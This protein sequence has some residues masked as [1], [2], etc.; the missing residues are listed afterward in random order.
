MLRH[1][2]CVLSMFLFIGVQTLSI[3]KVIDPTVTKHWTIGV[4]QIVSHPSLDAVYKGMLEAL[5]SEGIEPGKNLTIIYENAQGNTINAT[6]IAKKLASTKTLECIVAI[7]TPSAQSV[8][9]ATRKQPVPVVFAAVSDPVMAR[10]ISEPRDPKSWVTGVTDAQPIEMQLDFIKK[11]F[12][13]IKTLGF[14]Y[15]HSE[16][17]S[18][19]TLKRLKAYTESSKYRIQ[20]IEAT[21]VSTQEVSSAVKQLVRKVDALYIPADNT[22]VSALPTVLKT[23]MAHTTPVFSSDPD[24]VQQGVLMSVGFS[25]DAVGR[26]VGQKVKEILH[27]GRS[28]TIAVESPQETQYYVN[29]QTAKVLQKHLPNWMLHDPAVI[30]FETINY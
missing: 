9:T 26:L 19:Q 25:Y 28:G 23:C 17:N 2:W 14:L 6:Q 18:V 20:I 15:N 10:L 24:L 21:A 7:S 22:V 16:I 8:L 30:R 1:I 4:T 27:G 12:P 3:A 29:L 5:I 11:Y 13:E